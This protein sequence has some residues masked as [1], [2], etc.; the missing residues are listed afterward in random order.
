MLR[1]ALYSI[2]VLSLLASASLRAQVLINEVHCGTPDFV[3]LINTGTTAVDIGGWTLRTWYRTTATG[4]L[5]AEATYTF[6]VGTMLGAQSFTVRHDSSTGTVGACSSY[7][8][9][10]FNWTTTYDVEVVLRNAAGVGVDYV[11]RNPFGGANTNLPTNLSWTGA[12]ATT[13]DNFR[14]NSITNTSG[15]ADWS[16]STN[17]TG[18]ALNPLQSFPPPTPP[19]SMVVSTNGAGSVSVAISTFPAKPFAEFYGLYSFINYTPNGSGP[20]FGVGF[21]AL[22][23]INE[24]L[25]PG[26]PFHSNLDGNG[27]FSFALP[28]GM[29]AGLLME[30]TCLVIDG[31]VLV[32]P[33]AVDE[34][35]F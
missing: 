14:R 33:A 23:V 18:C 12:L 30:A 26:S 27:A 15:A 19:V 7:V 35:V 8:G 9:W 10:N 6:P 5:T 28:G 16:V 34:T 17:A 25:L 31:S 20:L 29:P 22:V 4:A 1:K 2:T 13:G 3:E 11:H 21:D 24:P 32:G